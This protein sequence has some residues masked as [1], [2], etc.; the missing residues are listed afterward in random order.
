MPAE[1]FPIEAGHIMCFARACGDTSSTFDYTAVD[2]D[3]STVLAPLTFVQ[4][5]AQCDPDYP[6]RPR[7]GTPW[8]GARQGS[9]VRLHAEQHY[10][11]TR[12]VRAGDV[13]H[14]TVLPSRTWQKEGRR[15]GALAFTETVTEYREA[16]GDVV[17]IARGVSVVTSQVAQ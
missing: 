4:A 12:A 7:P 1:H 11:Y 16:K 17:V 3:P 10:E 8:P 2:R 14:P 9:G 13:L 5:N 15:G 6:L